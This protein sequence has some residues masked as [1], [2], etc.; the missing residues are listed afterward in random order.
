MTRFSTLRFVDGKPVE[1]NV[2]EIKQ[3]DMLKCPHCIM[4]AEHYRADG[5]C[6]CDDP[7]HTEMRAGGYRWKKGRW[8]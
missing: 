8:T 5:S 7:D 2:R 4:V 6:R 1:T 3:A